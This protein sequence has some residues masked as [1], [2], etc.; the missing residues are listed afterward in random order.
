MQIEQTEIKK[1]VLKDLNALDPITLF[2]EDIKEGEGKIII[3]CYGQSWSYYWGG[4]G[5]QNLTDFFLSCNVSYLVNCLWDHSKES[6][7]ND[8]EGI[9]SKVR[10]WV[11]ELRR[12]ERID[13]NNARA[14]YDIDDW[15]EYAPQHTYDSWRC[16][17]LV[18]ESEFGSLYLL[19]DNDIPQ[20]STQEYSYLTRIVESIRKAFD[21]LNQEN[22]VE[23][24]VESVAMAK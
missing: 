8:F 3:E 10:K 23:K 11:V 13:K 1:I 19:H 15:S 4:M 16:P 2:I 9:V 22:E 20:R 17:E 7:E 5:S 12:E 6:S 21:Q 14:L 24:E 18:D